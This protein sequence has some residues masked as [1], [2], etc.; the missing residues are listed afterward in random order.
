VD[1]ASAE[2]GV[3]LA[4]QTDPA[5][6]AVA[7]IAEPTGDASL[8]PAPQSDS[9]ASEVVPEPAASTAE[10][11]DTATATSP[12][13]EGD[14][15]PVT[16]PPASGSAQQQAGQLA[17]AEQ[18]ANAQANTVQ[19]QPTNI[20]APAV[21]ASPDSNIVIVQTN[22]ASAGAAAVN[23]SSII[24]TINQTQAGGGAIQL[25]GTA[26]GLDAIADAFNGVGGTFVWIWDWDWTWTGPAID[27]PTIDLPTID[28]PTLGDW[29]VPGITTPVNGEQPA[30]KSPVTKNDDLHGAATVVGP[31]AALL[32]ASFARASGGRSVS[33]NFVQESAASAPLDES[34]LFP[35]APAAPGGSAGGSGISPLTFVFGAL[36]ALGIQ[37]A[38]ALS[39]LGRRFS[40]AR[41]AWR[42]QAYATPLER[43]G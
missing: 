40:L 4:A 41:V 28:L 36:L 24:Q 34:V 27:V 13:S 15:T 39:L 21:V 20:A 31:P 5:A 42:R 7:P 16:G 12:A 22:S 25:P 11:A 17:T 8:A 30:P 3:D 32:D 29:P 23:T 9:A 38:S 14:E 26:G 6:E 43:P 10:S 19:T 18:V 33:S 35:P 1:S 2:T 37:L